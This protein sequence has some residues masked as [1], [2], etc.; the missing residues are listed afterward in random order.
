MCDVCVCAC[1]QYW[2]IIDHTHTVDDRVDT[3]IIYNIIMIEWT[4]DTII[5][6]NIIMIEWTLDIILLYTTTTVLGK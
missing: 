6:Y 4:L 3:I 5:I 1:V 2:N